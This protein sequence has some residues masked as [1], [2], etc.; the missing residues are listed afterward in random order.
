MAKESE[1][2]SAI[3]DY[4]TLRHHFFIRLNNIP[5][6]FIDKSGQRQFRRLGKFARKGMADIIVMPTDKPDVFLEVKQEKG[7]MSPDQ[8]H[9]A[10]DVFKSGREYHVVTSIDDVQR[11]G[12]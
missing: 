8:H 9:F 5:A 6:T 1:I 11:I 12:L 3:C 4:L 2:Q 10:Q 7:R